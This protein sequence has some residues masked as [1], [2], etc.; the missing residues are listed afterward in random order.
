MEFEVRKLLQ[1][2]YI[3]EIKYPK[4]LE[5]IVM[6]QKKTGGWHMCID[7]TNHNTASPKDSYPLPPV[8]NLIDK[9]SWCK[10]LNFL[11]TYL[12]YNQ[13]KMKKEDEEKTTFVTTQDTFCFQVMPFGLKNP[14]TTFQRFM[15]KVFKD[16]IGRNVEV[17]VDDILVW[18][19]RAEDHLS[20]LHETFHN[21]S[22]VGLQLKA[23][24]RTFD[25]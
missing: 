10:L 6:V 5:N 22:Q 23:E 19:K 13:I 20:N 1:A 18:S 11:D 9:S 21:L 3:R 12:G 2:K 7:F 15:D 8:D 4:W 17:Y 16:Q 25:V 14:G 24:K